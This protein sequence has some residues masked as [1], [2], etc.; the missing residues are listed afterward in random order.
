M[1]DIS[2]LE[3]PEELL[4]VEMVGKGTNVLTTGGE[5]K[6]QSYVKDSE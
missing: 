6:C 4:S 5:E 3:Q 1:A 2:K